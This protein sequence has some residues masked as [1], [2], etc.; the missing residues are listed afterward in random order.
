[1]SVRLIFLALRRRRKESKMLLWH[2]FI[3]RVVYFSWMDNVVKPFLVHCCHAKS[4]TLCRNPSG[5]CFLI[6]QQRA[7]KERS[8]LRAPVFLE[9]IFSG[10]QKSSVVLCV[11]FGFFPARSLP[12]HL[13]VRGVLLTVNVYVLWFIYYF[14][15]WLLA[16]IHASVCLFIL[17]LIYFWV[18]LIF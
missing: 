13:L 15:A 2:F 14:L 1:M 8:K 7:V 18:S 3:L 12:S 6:L 16:F 10:W 11:K 5:G 4:Q 9:E 17:L